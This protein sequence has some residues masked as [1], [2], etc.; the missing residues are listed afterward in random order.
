[1]KILKINVTVTE[2]KKKSLNCGMEPTEWMGSRY[3]T[4]RD[5][6]ALKGDQVP[7]D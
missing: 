7:G 4:K 2:K 3:Y 5:Q 6:M 1:M